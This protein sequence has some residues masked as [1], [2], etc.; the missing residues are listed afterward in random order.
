[1]SELRKLTPGPASYVWEADY[2]GP[3]WQGLVLGDNYARLRAI[4]DEYDPD[5]LF[6]PSLRRQRDWSADGF[7]RF[8]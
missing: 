7:T 4:E 8:K 3:N 5:G 1:M 2:F 6:S